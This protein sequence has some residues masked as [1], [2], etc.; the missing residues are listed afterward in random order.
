[1]NVLVIDCYDSFTYN[2]CQQIG[3]AGCGI[4]VVKNDAP[5]KVLSDGDYDRIVLSP[6]PGIPE[7][8][9][10]CL[11][12]L[13]TLSKTV[14]TLGICLGHQAICIAFNGNVIKTT[15]FHGKVS[16]IFHDRKSIF[17]GLECGFQATRYHSLAAEKESLPDCLEITAVSSDD[18]CIMGLRHRDF[19][20]EGVQFHPESI[21][22]TEG[23]H[24]INNFLESGV[25]HDN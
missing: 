25:R 17:E 6:G 21:L 3:K 13:N 2:L 20:I 12:A 8:S 7:K 9:G 22:T 16:G 18:N 23:D 14:P 11:K 1:M 4:T 5:E 15:P 10:L 19:P 24:L